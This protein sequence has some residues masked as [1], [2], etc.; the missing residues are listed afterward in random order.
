MA[1]AS[2]VDFIIPVMDSM[3]GTGEITQLLLQDGQELVKALTAPVTAFIYITL[4][5]LHDRAY[6]LEPLVRKMRNELKTIPGCYGACWGPSVERKNTEVGVV[7][8]RSMTVC[9]LSSSH[10]LFFLRLSLE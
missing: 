9:L 7:G 8:W 1:D 10:Y 3:V 5:P 2:Y 6:E 4:R